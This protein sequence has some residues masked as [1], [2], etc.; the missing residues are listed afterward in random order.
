MI[1]KFSCIPRVLDFKFEAGTS[2]GVLKSRKIWWIKA[3]DSGNPDRFGWGEAA[4]LVKL[5]IDD[6]PDFEAQ[7]LE[8]L[9]KFR[10]I[11]FP[12]EERKTLS[13]IQSIV[14]SHLPSFRFALEMAILDL[15]QGGRKRFFPNSFYDNKKPIPINGLIWMGEK[16]FM[17]QQID[18]KISQGFS[19]IKMKIGA[20]DFDQELGLLKY[21]R[22]EY[23]NED[24][25]LRV[26]ANGAFSPAEAMEKL[27]KLA[28][29]DI[30]SIEQPIRAGQWEEMARLCEKTPLP[31][32]LDEELIGVKNKGPLLEQINPQH[33]ILKPTLVGGFLETKEWIAEAENRNIGWWM[34]SALES[35]IGLNAISQL[36]S[37][38]D[39]TIPQGLG[40]GQLYYNNLQSPLFISNGEIKYNS[41]IPWEEPS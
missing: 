17:R 38:Y 25:V 18:A 16:E 19:C 5:S 28:D 31:I 9:D 20:I 34:T 1:L 10:S 27:G 11:D 4:P 39:P 7:V 2:R 41:T 40:T 14:P 36:A 33:I 6:L 3:Q 13:F 23:G 21:I 24:L 29:L 8:L 26:D 35:N 22:S 32:A 12:K 15:M 37:S 30:H